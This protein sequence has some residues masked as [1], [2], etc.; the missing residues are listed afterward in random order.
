M[1]NGVFFFPFMGKKFVRA[2]RT[3]DWGQPRFFVHFA[4]TRV[5]GDSHKQD[6]VKIFSVFFVQ[7]EYITGTKIPFSLPM[8]L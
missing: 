4:Q 5:Q 8:M 3:E 2:Q 7:S 1:S 6:S